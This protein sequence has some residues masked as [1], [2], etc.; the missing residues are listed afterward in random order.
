MK[1]F[2]GFPEDVQFG[3]LPML[4]F[5]RLLPEIDDIDELKATIYLL[6][7]LYESKRHPRFISDRELLADRA[8]MSGFDGEE[9]LRRGLEKAVLRGAVLSLGVE[10]DGKKV[11]LYFI[12]N[13]EGR[14]ARGGIGRG[15]IDVGVIPQEE[16]YVGIDEKHNIFALYEENIGMLSPMVAEELKD[17]E[18]RYPQSW[19]E[20]A[21]REAVSLNK[22]NWRYIQAILK[23]WESEGKGHGEPGRG[24]KADRDKYIKGKYGH[25]VRR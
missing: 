19:I 8:V 7:T 12:N 13:E 24:P 20:D 17:A 2:E 14:E 4:F 11:E 18:Q 9:A 21:F 25:V 1:S 5:S 15:E 10:Q 23:R 22:R 3:A 6:R 16:P